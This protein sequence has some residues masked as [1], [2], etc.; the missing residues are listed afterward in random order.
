MGELIGYE[1]KGQVS[2]YERTDGMP[3]VKGR[4]HEVHRE[5][6]YYRCMDS[7]ECQSKR[8]EMVYCLGIVRSYMQYKS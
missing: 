5:T 7:W 3:L 8:V 1:M 4:I 6:N 2:G